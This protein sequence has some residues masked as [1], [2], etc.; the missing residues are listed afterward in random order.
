MA[1]DRL[2]GMNLTGAEGILRRE[3][4][5]NGDA[6]VH[7]S[8]LQP[9]AGKDLGEPQERFRLTV[10]ADGRLLDLALTGQS[11]QQLTGLAGVPAGFLEK[12]PV[13]V[14]LATLRSCLTLAVE[15]RDDPMLLL[16]LGGD[17][18]F[19]RGILPA[20][21]VRYDDRD[22]LQDVRQALG[23]REVRVT[24]LLVQEDVFH[25]RIATREAVELGAGKQN[26]VAW[27]G[28]DI[29]SSETGRLPLELRRVLVRLVCSNGMTA[30]AGEQGAAGRRKTGISRK[31]I[32]E[33]VQVGLRE[34]L[35]WSREPAERL[36]RDRDRM[37]QHPLDEMERVF[38]TYGL[39]NPRSTGG[40]LVRNVI[41]QQRD[42]FG[43]SRFNF[44]Q[45]FTRT[46]RALDPRQRS[47]WEDGMGMYLFEEN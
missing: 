37:I 20:S 18:T 40:R 47:L 45:A 28:I 33:F 41:A 10:D 5:A 35:A 6:Y 11:L 1:E 32:E 3:R 8:R 17:G 46:A 16:R 30:V 27:P 7:L 24:D 31:G 29:L 12:I 36:R 43:V 9:R 26:D 14:G 22:L 39:G 4:R 23:E 15:T 2:K 25:I 34:S 13:S 42:L 44:I 21:F 19:V 38:R